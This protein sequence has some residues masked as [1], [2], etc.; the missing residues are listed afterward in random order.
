MTLDEE[1]SHL[2]TSDLLHMLATLDAR[3]RSD[4]RDADEVERLRAL[5]TEIDLRIPPRRRP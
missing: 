3:E 5:R 2:P 4:V 1:M